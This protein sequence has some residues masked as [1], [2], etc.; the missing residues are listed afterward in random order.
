MVLEMFL[1]QILIVSLH[2][3]HVVVMLSADGV[4]SKGFKCGLKG[5]GQIFC[6]EIHADGLSKHDW[7]G[8]IFG[9]NVWLSI[10]KYWM[11]YENRGRQ[12]G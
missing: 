6:L 1:P 11:K 9:S 7:S 10:N 5:L 8:A 2:V 3:L 4:N 12:R